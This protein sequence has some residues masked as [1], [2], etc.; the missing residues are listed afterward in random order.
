MSAFTVNS[1]P[2][3]YLEV[4]QKVLKPVTVMLTFLEQLLTVEVNER[5]AEQE[6]Y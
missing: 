2:H 4:G 5:Q 1:H 6:F 3:A